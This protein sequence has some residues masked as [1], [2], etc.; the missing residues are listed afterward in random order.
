MPKRYRVPK[1]GPGELRLEW[2]K[3]PKDDWDVQYYSTDPLEP[4]R[5]MALMHWAFA[6]KRPNF[7]GRLE[8]SFIEELIQ[9]GYDIETI[10]FSIKKKATT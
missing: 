1:M 8:P 2:G 4:K 5:H 7:A 6:T 10:K 3:M 9:R